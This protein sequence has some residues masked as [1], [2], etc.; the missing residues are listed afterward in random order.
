MAAM[1]FPTPYMV[2]ARRPPSPTWKSFLKNYIES[3][4]AIDFFVLPTVQNQILFV[5]LYF[6]SSLSCGWNRFFIAS[7]E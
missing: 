6:F 7:T 4:V 2:R 1:G 5:F 3:I